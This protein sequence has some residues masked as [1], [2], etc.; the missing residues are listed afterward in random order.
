M[1]YVGEKFTR[2]DIS[3]PIFVLGLGR[4][5][6]IKSQ[7]EENFGNCHVNDYVGDLEVLK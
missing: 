1:S 2:L 6:S 3:T 5:G 7:S 4:L